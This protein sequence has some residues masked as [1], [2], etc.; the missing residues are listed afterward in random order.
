MNQSCNFDVLL[1][2]ESLEPCYPLLNEERQKKTDTLAVI[3]NHNLCDIPTDRQTWQLYDWP[4]PE[5]RVGKTVFSSSF[6][7][8]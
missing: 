7:Q 4:G 5:G 1:D 3:D 6:N 8:V 2:L